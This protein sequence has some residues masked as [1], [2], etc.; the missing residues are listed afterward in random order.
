MLIKLSALCR[1]TG[2][3]QQTGLRPAII[4]RASL[5]V[6]AA[7]G[8]KGK[9][10]VIDLSYRKALALDPKRFATTFDLAAH[11]ILADVASVMMPD[12][13]GVQ[14]LLYKLNVYTEGGHFKVHVDTPRSTKMFGSLVVCLPC[15]H[16]GGELLAG[17]AETPAAPAQAD[18]AFQTTYIAACTDGFADDLEKMLQANEGTVKVDL[19]RQCLAAGGDL[20][21]LT[22]QQLAVQSICQ[23]K[24]RRS[25]GR[26]A[27]SVTP[28]E[29]AYRWL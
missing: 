24:A 16:S 23:R 21:S 29:L 22:E 8:K 7:A 26:I 2:L 18:P 4:G 3:V 9:V 25:H 11:N 19:V 28:F 6:R 10:A 15:E 27:S 12:A 14:A 5:K 20:F 1:P 17:S 13:H